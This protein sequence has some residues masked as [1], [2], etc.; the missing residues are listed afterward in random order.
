M[1]YESKPS[2]LVVEDE[3]IV[4]ADIQDRLRALGYVVAGDA[5]TGTEAIRK[6]AELKPDLILM[7]IMLK[8]EMTGT[9]AA[10]HIRSHFHL[11]VIYLTANSNDETVKR[12]RD[13]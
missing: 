7:D 3:A 2:I 13:T 6:T 1:N 11:P 4:S 12:A 10:S 5:D 9:E 8:G